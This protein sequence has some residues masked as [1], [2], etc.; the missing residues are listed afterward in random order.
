MMITPTSAPPRRTSGPG[1]GRRY[2]W[3]R[4]QVGEWQNW[5][6][7]DPTDSSVTNAE[8]LRR[9]ANIRS[10]AREWAMRNGLDVQTRR[11]N[12]G[13]VVDLLFTPLSETED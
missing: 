9:Y 13:R 1:G 3:S 10:A 2:D 12:H 11:V 4:V 7:I 6:T 8:A 5:I